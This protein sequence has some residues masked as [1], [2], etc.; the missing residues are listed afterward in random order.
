MAR[1]RTI[2]PEFWSS[3]QVMESRPLARLLFIGL[4]NFCDDG[5]N[6]PLAPRTIKALVFPGDDITTEAVSEL[7]GELE[8]SG[9]TR[10]YT[11]DGKLYLHVNGWKHQKIE[12]RTFK[13]PK[14]PQLI[15]E[16]NA[17]DDENRPTDQQEVVE[18]SS[19]GGGVVVEESSTGSRVLAPG[20]DVDV[21]G[22]GMDQHHSLNAS[23]EIPVPTGAASGT[24]EGF[25]DLEDLP[26]E[27][28]E[29]LV[30]SKAPVEMTL[31]WMPDAYLLKTY[32]THFGISTDLFTK[33]AVAPFT[34]HHET[35]GALQTQSKWVSLLVKWVKG[36]LT[37]ASN[38]RQFPKPQAISRHTLTESRDYKAGTKDNAN[39]TF[40]L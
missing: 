18:Q 34:A 5:G 2:K 19:N 40:R 36:D 31:D 27:E 28:A 16:D 17:A 3:E 35:E 6:H 14:P 23:E 29:P 32:C 26:P 22:K 8:G 1:I 33:Q 30:D 24:F 9:L 11:V 25:D 13:Y 15:V 7:L 20:R 37:R 12:K 10:S 4:W 21:E 39:G 38:I